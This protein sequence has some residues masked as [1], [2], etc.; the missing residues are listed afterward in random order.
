MRKAAVILLTLLTALA[1]GTAALAADAPRGYRKGAGYQYYA[2]GAYPQGKNG[3]VKPLLW[4]ALSVEDGRALLL[5]E[6]VIDAK[7][8]LFESDAEVIAAH[9]YRRIASFAESDL[10]AWMNGVM[11]P[12][13]MGDTGLAAALVAG[14]Y[15]LLYPPTDEQLL[16]P[17]YGF[18]SARYGVNPVRC[19]SPTEYALGAGVYRQL[20]NRSSP[21]WVANVKAAEGYKMQIV[22][23][24]GHL[25][26]G[27]YTRTD[28][29]IR[30]AMT[31]DLSRCT[32]TGGDGSEN[33][34]FQVALKQDGASPAA[35]APE[36]GEA[37]ASA[38]QPETATP[39]PGTAA[40]GTETA[41]PSS[42]PA[43]TPATTAASAPLTTPL[44]SVSF[45]TDPTPSPSVLPGSTPAPSAEAGET[46]ETV[47]LSLIGD[48]SIGDAYQYRKQASGV[49]GVIA[50]N[51][52]EWPFSL[53]SRYLT[54]D[55]LTAAN[56]EVTLTERSKHIDIVYPL[57]AP[58]VNANVLTLGGV[59]VVNTVNNHSFDFGADGYDDTLSTLDLAGVQHFGTALRGGKN[60]SDLT[61]MTDVKGVRFGFIGYS[62]PQEKTLSAIGERIQALRA[63][64]C[65]VVI[66]SLH[67]GRETYSTPNSGQPAYA[68]KIIDMGADVVWGHHPHVLQPIQFYKG[69]PVF[70]STGNFIFGTMS[71][72]DPSTG[73]FQLRYEKT[74]DGV[75]LKS[76]TV[77]PCK[78][79][80]SGDYRPYEVTDAAERQ[81]VWGILRSR[82]TYDGYENLPEAFLETGV[83]Y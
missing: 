66:V 15:G 68:A 4:R 83:V 9:A 17:E 10:C 3:E 2:I 26:Y 8:I 54:A 76:L 30:P 11:L 70:F 59:D 53:V 62:Y 51:G 64:G 19:A 39:L 36:A 32:F 13:I 71:K 21:Y 78:T 29:G 22:G 1:L 25:S 5:T 14:E 40:D 37:Q 33:S 38:T 47:T 49:T 20:S 74:A 81:A 63:D 43:E 7:Q 41:S 28:I 18:S 44:P 23:Y 60:Y 31:L 55:D 80:G 50:Q 16:I 61:L 6:Y 75:T 52:P 12:E 34:P 58:P 79:Q 67:W 45:D 65:D 82:K 77:I 24:D 73:I 27:A 35:A 48:V 42:V 57:V 56:L 46:G 72:V 69:K